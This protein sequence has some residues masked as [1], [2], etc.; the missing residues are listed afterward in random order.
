MDLLGGGSKSMQ[1]SRLLAV[2]WL[3]CASLTMQVI[4]VGQGA[5]ARA[6]GAP[7]GDVSSPDTGPSD[8]PVAR[9]ISRAVPLPDFRFSSDRADGKSTAGGDP[10]AALPVEFLPLPAHEKVRPPSLARAEIVVGTPPRSERIR[11]PP[12]A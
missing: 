9:Q 6:A 2:L 7:A 8:R 12:E 11:A 4:A 5:S 1:A 10:A 3:F